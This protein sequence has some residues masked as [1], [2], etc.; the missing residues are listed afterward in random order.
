MPEAD[1]TQEAPPRGPLTRLT[2]FETVLLVGGLVL[3][4]VLLFTMAAPSGTD[5]FLSPPLVAV[6]GVILVWP[7][8]KQPSVRALLFSGAFLLVMWFLVR[9]STV[10]LPFVVVYLLAYLFNPI[11]TAMHARWNV[12]RGASAAAVTTLLLGLFALFILLLVPN[13]VG[14]L[15][16]LGTRLIDAIGQLRAWMTTTPLLDRLEETGLLEK[17]EV[18]QRITNVAQEQAQALASWIPDA[19]QGVVRSLSSLLGVITI[20]AIV[21]VIL[22]YTLKD[23]PYIHRRLVELFPTFGGR[24]EYLVKAG[25]IVGSYLRGQL[26]ISAIAAFNVSVALLIFDVPFALLIG[27]ATGLLNMIPQLGAILTNIVG[28][29]LAVIFGDPWFIKALIVFGVLMGQSILESSVLTP[30][31][32]SHQVGLHPVLILLSLFAFG[33]F[34]GI[35]GLLIAVP[36]TAIIMTF[37]KAYRDDFTL[38]FAS[39]KRPPSRLRWPRRRRTPAETPPPDAAQKDG[40]ASADA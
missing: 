37:Y 18:V 25:D 22:F 13:I 30:K 24:R 33:F 7:L 11:V 14:E 5:G 38:D 32:M 8:R 28:I 27:I 21:P 15:K 10:L 31:I 36:A 2:A 34:L 6:A 29:T 23:Y 26:V 40:N 39:Y 1:P 19:V 3:F 35:F 4:L 12:P 16:V 9:L 17:R 20:V